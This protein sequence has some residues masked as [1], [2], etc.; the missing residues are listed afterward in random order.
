MREMTTV[1]LDDEHIKYFKKHPKINK[2]E[3]V[4][5]LLDQYLKIDRKQK[6]D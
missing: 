1:Y 4:R 5:V 6:N 3:L 2:S